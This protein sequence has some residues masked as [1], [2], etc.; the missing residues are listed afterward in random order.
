[1]KRCPYSLYELG[2]LIRLCAL[3]HRDGIQ[4]EFKRV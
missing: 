1:M 3:H 2:W 4:K